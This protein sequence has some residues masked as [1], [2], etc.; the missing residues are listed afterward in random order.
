[1]REQGQAP[2]LCDQID[3]A[4]TAIYTACSFQDLTGQRIRKVIGVL[5][6]LETRINTMIEIWGLDGASAPQEKSSAE[7]TLLHG[8][9]PPG[10]GLGQDDVDMVMGH[11]ASAARP[12][13]QEYP[14]FLDGDD[15]IPVEDLAAPVTELKLVPVSPA[16]RHEGRA[17]P[18]QESPREEARAS[19]P[20]GPL[21]PI[22]ALSAEE[23]IALFS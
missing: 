22:M 6:Y 13:H 7:V 4:A 14:A 9:A 10:E 11:A 23:K 21:A 15:L 17:E 12:R 5:R 8:P 3:A 2:E 1:M 16:P 18:H 19:A 20:V